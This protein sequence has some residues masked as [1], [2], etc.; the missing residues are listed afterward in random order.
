MAKKKAKVSNP[1]RIKFLTRK[2]KEYSKE[3]ILKA[4]QWEL[5]FLKKM[6]ITGI[7]FIF[8]YPVICGGE[9]LYIIDFYLPKEKVAIELDGQWH[10]TPEAME[11]DKIR[12]KLL[13]KEGISVIR[14]MNIMEHTI[15][16]KHIKE[17]LGK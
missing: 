15:E 5:S 8:Q 12:T 2:G 7:P 9:R 14:I 4:T 17:L 11:N 1:E 10:Y 16:P 6:K 3:L 13:K